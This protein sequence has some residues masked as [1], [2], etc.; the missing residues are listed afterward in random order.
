[1]PRHLALSTALLAALLPCAPDALAYVAG[2]EQLGPDPDFEFEW[3]G[4][5]GWKLGGY[6]TFGISR[7]IQDE[8][9]YSEVINCEKV[10]KSHQQTLVP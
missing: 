7:C 6:E 4:L 8:V 3:F 1:M 10:M 2:N 9:G 5:Q